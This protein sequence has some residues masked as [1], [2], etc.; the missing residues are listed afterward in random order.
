MNG[1]FI[2]SKRS[3][4]NLSLSLLLVTL[5]TVSLCFSVN[6][7]AF[8]QEK[9]YIF[10]T[11]LIAPTGNPIRVQFA[12]L[13]TQELL[14]VGIKATLILVG[15]DV[16]I[17]R[18][19][20]SETHA[21]YAGGGFDIGFV[22]WSGGIVP[23]DLFQFFHSSNIDP[24]SWASNYYPVN[25]KTL[26]EMLEF[27]MNTTDFAQRKAWIGKVL[28]AIVWDIHPVTG[29]YQ[30][31]E[32]YY[33]RDNIRGFCSNRFPKPEELYFAN[34]QSAGH[35]Q[36]NEI[37]VASVSPP[38]D[39]NPVVSN[40]WYDTI[41]V[42]PAFT[43]LLERDKN[44]NFVPGMAK[45]FPYPVAVRNNYT[46]EISSKDVNTA[47]VWELKL[48]E[49]VYWH[50]GYGYRMSNITHRDILRFDAD[51]VV[52]YYTINCLDYPNGP[53]NPLRSFFQ[54]VFGREPE[55]AIIKVDRFTVQFHLK[56]F[57]S[58]L[59]TMLGTVLPQ[60]ILDPNYD[61]LGLGP[62]VRADKTVA[63]KYSG[64]HSDDYNLGKRSRGDMAYPATIGNGAYVLYPGTNES[65]QTVTLTK[66]NHYFKDNAS[67]W[68]SLIANRPDKYIYTWIANK[69]AAEIALAEGDIDIMDS[70]YAA[71]RDYSIMI[72]KP[73]I[74]ATKQ[75]DWG[76]QSMG[77]NILHGAQGYL[78][79]KWIRLA[80]SH[81][82]PRQ[83][84]I[85]ALLNGLGQPSF[86]PF[87]QQSP[88]WP[89][90]LEPIVYNVTK[91]L[92]YLERAGFTGLLS[93]YNVEY[94]SG[95]EI[96]PFLIAIG[97][98]TVLFSYRNR[99]NK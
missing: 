19:M 40:S 21:D 80:L 83:Q 17:T 56:N 41:A 26:D 28:K 27:T 47:T 49:D 63:S 2:S 43:G 58:D 42:A 16:L 90:D 69:D 36:V 68:S 44:L 73:G 24:A 51:D 13:T 4:K 22:G 59:F 46:G 82:V 53:S 89:D 45:Y 93:R 96:L 31:E 25:N 57:Y 81:L 91:A 6:Q 84:I 92:E 20:G 61:A 60:H 10:S 3:R 33:L 37:L 18:M 71:G 30:H 23:T 70:R 66:W 64:W 34:G 99:K 86:V 11:T 55:K 98:I 38:Y 52:W 78:T 50:E 95:L 5:I 67:D 32:V 94:S 15:W 48:R 79:N 85:T 97:T 88:F 12:Q 65:T 75:L 9:E 14:N 1:R 87:P 29:I 76:Y 39:F 54:Y 35:G 7:Q 72:T 8:S 62:G 74:N 77:Y